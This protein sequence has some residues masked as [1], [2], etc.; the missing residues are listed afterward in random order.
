MSWVITIPKTTPWAEYQKEL[1]D[2]ADGSMV[3]NY[4][5]RY[6]PGEMKPGDKCYLVHDGRVRGWMAIVGLVDAKSDWRC[7][8][9]GKVWP[10]GKYIQRS[11]EFHKV[12]GP[13][14]TGFRGV[15]KF[16]E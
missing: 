2:V 15:R 7:E 14:M 9:T 16:E 11:G 10:A 8:T 5:T 13:E 1:D 3:M 6:F 12:D 4:R